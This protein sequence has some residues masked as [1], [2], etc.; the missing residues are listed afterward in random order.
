MDIG[1]RQK[2]SY[3]STERMPLAREP[4]TAAKYRKPP[5]IDG[6]NDQLGSSSCFLSNTVT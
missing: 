3:F 2:P 1:N 4:I 6:P 5:Y